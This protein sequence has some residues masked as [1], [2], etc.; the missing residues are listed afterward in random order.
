MTPEEACAIVDNW[1]DDAVKD[2]FPIQ[3]RDRFV[4]AREAARTL[5][6]ALAEAQIEIGNLKAD[7]ANDAAEVICLRQERDALRRKLDAAIRVAEVA[8]SYIDSANS[9]GRRD[10]GI[11][12]E[13]DDALA[14]L[15]ADPS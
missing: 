8:R 14:A 5:R 13:L 10:I 6:Q 1:A 3:G 4:E 7:A 9:L 11:L 15:E 2:L 12:H